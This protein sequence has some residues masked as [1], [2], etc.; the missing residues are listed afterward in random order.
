MFL[1]KIPITQVDKFKATP[2]DLFNLME[3]IT[4]GQILAFIA[5][6]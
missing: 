2:S 3:I 1:E 4:L 6:Y 5:K